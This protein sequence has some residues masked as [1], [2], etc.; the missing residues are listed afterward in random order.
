M[1]VMSAATFLATHFAEAALR[2]HR[3]QIS[4]GEF[5]L[6]LVADTAG[7]LPS[8]TREGTIA[9]VADINELHCSDGSAWA[10]CASGGGGGGGT[11]TSVGLS[12]PAAEWS[13]SG[14]PVTTS[15]TLTVSK[16]NQSANTVYAGPSSGGASAPAFRALVSA[17]IPAT[18]ASNTSGNAATAT[19]LAADPSDCAIGEYA[20]SIDAQGNL[21]CSTPS[22]GGSGLTHP[23]VMSRVALSS[24]G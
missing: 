1:V 15:G 10:A 24:G 21:T 12:M 3:V 2:V 5:V 19:A 4:A 8:G 9:W 13:I 18:I 23:Q 14:S 17:D 16:T 20:H 7:D 11:V 22:G 6:I